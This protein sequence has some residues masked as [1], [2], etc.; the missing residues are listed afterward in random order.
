MRGE[1]AEDGVDERR[2]GGFA[3]ALDEVD[4]VVDG[5]AGRDALEEVELVEAE[6]EGERDG[7]VELRDG[8]FEMR[9][10]QGIEE[11]ALAEDSEGE[12][13]GERGVR[14]LHGGGE[15]GVENVRGVGAFGF[16]AA[17]GFEGD[18]AGGRNVHG[19]MK[20]YLRRRA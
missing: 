5:S 9:L 14:G 16:D 7:E 20:A 3:G 4:G 15:R 17:K 18:E 12:F 10:E 19:T 13:G 2:G 11:A 8:L 1:A 6:A